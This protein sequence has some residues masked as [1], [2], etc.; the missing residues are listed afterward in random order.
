MSSINDVKASDEPDA[1]NC[2]SLLLENEIDD[3]A[4]TETY[5]DQQK[6]HIPEDG[7]THLVR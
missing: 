2:R 1:D 3:S 5:T 6:V 4:Q 7:P